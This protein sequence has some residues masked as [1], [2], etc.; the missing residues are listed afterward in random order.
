M[1]LKKNTSAADVVVYL[2]IDTTK[3]VK[4]FIQLA[5]PKLVVFIKYEIW[6]NYLK[7]LKAKNIPTVLVSA[8]F[9]P[10][11]IYFKGYGKF[12]RKHLA[13]FHHIFV[14]NESS[15]QLLESIQIKNTT[16][17]GDTRLDRVS[18]IFRA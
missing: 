13:T 18:E 10:N 7:E 17:S 5:N 16:I 6:P 8:L 9:K 3:N 1:K 14:Q 15:K 11:Q 2:P 12:M 4:L